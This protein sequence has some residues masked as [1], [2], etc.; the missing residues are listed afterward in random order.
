MLTPIEKTALTLLGMGEDSAAK[1]L[2]YFDPYQIQ[3]ISNAMT[4]LR[5]VDS[6]VANDVLSEFFEAYGRHSGIK[7][8]SKDFLQN[9]LQKSVGGD[10]AKEV[11]TKIF[12][13]ELEQKI[14][15]LEHADPRS[16]ALKL[17]DE[18]PQMSAVFLSLLTPKFSASVITN[19]PRELE[20]E[21]VLKIAKTKTID[22]GLA[23]DLNNL[24]DRCLE[25]T[26]N[27]ESS[28][29]DG[30]KKVADIIN[31][32][33]GDTDHLI[34]LIR[35]HSEELLDEIENYRYNFGVLMVQTERT[36]DHIVQ[37]VNINDWAIALRGA[38]ARIVDKVKASMPNRM[39]QSLEEQQELTGPQPSVR[40]H[41]MRAEIM[42]TVKQ[43]ARE[44]DVTLTLSEDQEMS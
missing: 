39:R 19:L 5:N 23:G 16:I 27:S 33:D 40:V 13:D 25:A 24:V 8:A 2:K 44:G 22:E 18:H 9:T 3:S 14:E 15:L 10:L 4:S 35:E 34:D 26:S 29:V 17:L 42:N 20:D 31:V 38:D 6:E 37:A 28:S 1:V 36:M 32:Y 30:V 11:L 7:A 41:E 21:L 12:G 43:L